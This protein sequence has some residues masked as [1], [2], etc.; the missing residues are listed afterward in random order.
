MDLSAIS[1][2]TTTRDTAYAER[3]A[4]ETAQIRALEG[5]DI[6]AFEALIPRHTTAVAEH[7]AAID[8]LE[9]LRFEAGLSTPRR[10]VRR[11]SW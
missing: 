7:C 3:T 4:I 11:G 8:A 6:A 2:A 10:P 5:G 1:A 9:A